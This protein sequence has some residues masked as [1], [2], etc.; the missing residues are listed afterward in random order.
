ME[1]RNQVAV[2]TGGA[3]GIGRATARQR[4]FSRISR[5]RDEKPAS[6]LYLVT[7]GDA[8]IDYRRYPGS[9]ADPS[10]SP[11]RHT[12]PLPCRRTRLAPIERSAVHWLTIWNAVG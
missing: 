2:V 11:N 12:Q 9:V 5:V 3:R 8:N 7:G 4:P 6:A 1:W 10:L